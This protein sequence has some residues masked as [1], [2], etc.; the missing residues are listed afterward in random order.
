[1]P[2]LVPTPIPADMLSAAEN[3]ADGVRTGHVTGLGIVVVL[4]GRRFFVDCFGTLAR[5]P[6]SGRGYVAALDD[7]LREM[8]RQQRDQPTTR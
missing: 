7:C 4:K 8:G 5:E 2:Q 6:H 3:L 1:M